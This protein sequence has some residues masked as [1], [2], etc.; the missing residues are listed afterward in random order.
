MHQLRSRNVVAVSLVLVFPN[1]SHCERPTRLAMRD[2]EPPAFV[3]SGSGDLAWI[4]VRSPRRQR[5]APGEE[6]SLYWVIEARTISASRRIED[7]S[8]LKYGEVPDGYIQ[9]LPERGE[10]PRLI[11]GDRYYVSI[12]THNAPGAAGYFTVEQRKVTFEPYP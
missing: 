3:L 9:T 7:L 8:P 6:A 10:A 2:G 1:L 11:D 5:D 4:R 12:S